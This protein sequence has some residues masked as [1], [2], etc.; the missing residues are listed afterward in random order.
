MARSPLRDDGSCDIEDVGLAHGEGAAEE[1][2]SH[3]HAEEH[4]AHKSVE[5]QEEVVDAAAIDIAFLAAE[6]IADGME[7]EAEKDEH[8]QPVGTAE[9]GAVEQ[10]EGGEEG[11]AEDHEGGECEFP[12]AAEGVDD[13]LTAG[14]TQFARKHRLSAMDKEK[15]HEQTAQNGYEEP[16]VV[17]KNCEFV[18]GQ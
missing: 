17:L 7:H 12:F 9:A 1:E 15:E 4:A 2:C 13:D 14:F 16:P 5:H 8:P 3:G 10:G 18:H 6:F 11:S